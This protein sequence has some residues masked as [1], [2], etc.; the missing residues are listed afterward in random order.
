MLAYGNGVELAP[1]LAKHLRKPDYLAH[2]P[3]FC[4]GQTAVFSRDFL[5][6]N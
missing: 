5:Q 3:T 2:R 4:L 6:Q 1:T